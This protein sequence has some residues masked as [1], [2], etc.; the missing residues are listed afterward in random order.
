MISVSLPLILSVPNTAQAAVDG[1]VVEVV[2]VFLHH[3]AAV[4]RR[5]VVVAMEVALEVA[6]VHYPA[7]IVFLSRS[8]AF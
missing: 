3:Q 2:M 6:L 4:D 5:V 8:W 7:K 1:Q